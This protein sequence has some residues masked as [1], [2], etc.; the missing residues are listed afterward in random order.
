M[1]DDEVIHTKFGLARFHG[2]RSHTIF[3]GDTI[4]VINGEY[5]GKVGTVKDTVGNVYR[6][7]NRI[8]VDLE[9]ELCWFY[10]WDIHPV[11]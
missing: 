2:T 10:P 11:R 4:R 8:V 5:A 6:S 9:D 1:A 7:D 3:I